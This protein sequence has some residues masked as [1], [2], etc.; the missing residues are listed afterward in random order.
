VDEF[1]DLLS[2]EP[3]SDRRKQRFAEI[4]TFI[5]SNERTIHEEQRL[6]SSP[7]DVA[8]DL[9]SSGATLSP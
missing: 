3:A 7:A 8:G 6:G 9:P 4:E 2:T 1:R 5:H